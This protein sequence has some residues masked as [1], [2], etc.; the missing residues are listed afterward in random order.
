MQ[1]L[2]AGTFNVDCQPRNGGFSGY[3][4]P[5][6]I[7]IGGLITAIESTDTGVCL[8]FPLDDDYQISIIV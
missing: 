5:A 7:F 6:G 8:V 4:L 3:A 1:V 2:V